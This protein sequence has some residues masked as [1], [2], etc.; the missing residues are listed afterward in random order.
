MPGASVDR[1]LVSCDVG[2]PVGRARP[3]V[4][5]KCGRNARGAR[6][7]EAGLA[8]SQRIGMES[9]CAKN[10]LSKMPKSS[11]VARGHS[12]TAHPSL[13]Y[14][15]SPN[16][17]QFAPSRHLHEPARTVSFRN[18]HP[19]PG[20]PSGLSSAAHR[21]QMSL[22]KRS[23]QRRGWR[24]A[25]WPTENRS[26]LGPRALNTLASSR[27]SSPLPLAFRQPLHEKS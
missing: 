19:E 27:P 25:I 10:T 21:S 5:L 22:D 16:G 1:S 20:G 14:P 23:R 17:T 4:E 24:L 15:A 8:G 9:G 7:Q 2:P 6:R 13:G 3:E 12:C 11:A 26:Q 18:A